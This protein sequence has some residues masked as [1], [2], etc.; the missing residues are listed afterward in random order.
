M[1]YV[2]VINYHMGRVAEEAACHQTLGFCEG[3]L[4]L[5]GA[6][7][8]RATFDE[9]AWNGAPTTLASLHWT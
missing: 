1:N 8:I 5:A 9:C 3:A 7:E 2:V 4:N 6:T